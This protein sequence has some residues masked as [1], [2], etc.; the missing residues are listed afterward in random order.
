MKLHHFLLMS[1]LSCLVLLGADAYIPELDPKLPDGAALP[2]RTAAVWDDAAVFHSFTQLG[3]DGKPATAQ[4]QVRMFHHGGTLF[5]AAWCRSAAAPICNSKGRD[6]SVWADEN[7]AFFIVPNLNEPNVF[8]QFCINRDGEIYDERLQDGSDWNAP[9][10]KAASHRS[11]NDT[12]LITRIDMA[13]LGLKTPLAGQAIRMNIGRLNKVSGSRELSTLMNFGNVFSYA[14]T[15]KYMLL[16]F[17]KGPQGRTAD[18]ADNDFREYCLDGDPELGAS[19]RWHHA[20]GANV[21]KWYHETGFNSMFLGTKTAGETCSIFHS[22]T[23]LPPPGTPCKLAF[24]ARRSSI[25]Q[26]NWIHARIHFKDNT[27]KLLSIWDG[28][29]LGNLGGEAPNKQFEHFFKRFTIPEQAAS[30]ELE[31][32]I[33]G[34][35]ELRVDAISIQ[36]SIAQTLK[37]VNTIPADGAQL[38]NPAIG[39]NWSLFT[40]KDVIPGTLTLQLSP[41]KA[42]PEQD[43]ITVSGCAL[44]PDSRSIW[45]ETLPHDGTWFWRVRFDGQDGGTWSNPTS[46]TLSV[47]PANET[48]PPVFG[49]MAPRGRLAQRPAQIFLPFSDGAVSS[50]IA[51]YKLFVNRQDWTAKAQQGPDGIRFTLTENAIRNFFEIDCTVTDKNG[52]SAQNY[53]FISL[54]P[55]RTAGAIDSKGFLTIDGQRIFPISDYANMVSSGF[56]SFPVMGFDSN[57]S[58]W[59]GGADPRIFP[60]LADA[61]RADVP[62]FIFIAPETLSTIGLIPVGSLTVKRYEEHVKKALRKLIGHPALYGLYIG[63]ESMDRGHKMASYQSFY[64]VLKEAA[65]DMLVSWLPTYGRTER[66]VWTDAAKAC[67]FYFWDNYCVHRNERHKFIPD[68][69]NLRQWSGS[70]PSINIMEAHAPTDDWGKVDQRFMSA[71]DLRFSAY[72]ALS[73]GSR[74]LCVYVQN[75]H[76]VDYGKVNPYDKTSTPEY[77][78]RLAGVIKGVRALKPFLLQDDAPNC[79]IAVISGTVRQMTKRLNGETLVISVNYANAPGALRLPAGKSATDMDSGKVLPKGSDIPLKPFGVSVVKL[80]E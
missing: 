60:L 72:A 50:G 32:R 40:Q 67:D 16:H 18:F 71:D 42:F 52:N 30:A 26:P 54:A 75:V 3:K 27:G 49:D 61:A 2:D 65:P 7:V 70:H 25:E 13:D 33:I 58:P 51:N 55:G 78:D 23:T 4:T 73:V 14:Q 43:T 68:F 12:I 59:I 34:P 53:D 28:P 22:L 24:S 39:F 15:E 9:S 64:R 56:V 11:G 37:P 44:Y 6:S 41:S 35:A 5:A 76:R 57:V 79:P 74:G 46:F 80:K 1:L 29:G 17:G 77:K 69:D 19:A 48:I 31:L 21:S 38:H 66:Q 45:T 20:S 8:F 10:F 63:D 62:Q 47:T 36:K